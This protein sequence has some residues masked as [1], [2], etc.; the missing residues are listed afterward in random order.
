[1]KRFA[2][3]LIAVLLVSGCGQPDDEKIISDVKVK[4]VE[5][6][7][8]SYDGCENYKFLSDSTAPEFKNAY[9]FRCDNFLNPNE[10]SF[11]EIKVY[12]HNNLVAV[13]G[14]VS[15]KTDLSRQGIRFVEFWDRDDG[16]EMQSKY[17]GR[18]IKDILG[19]PVDTYRS[20]Y[21]KF[22]K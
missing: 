9:L 22:C 16:V 4:I 11:S 21:Q 12:R 10:L 7:K 17:S 3:C 8:N 6:I 14:V 18:K 2:T 5:K 20:Y 13:C 19:S 1:M 15:G